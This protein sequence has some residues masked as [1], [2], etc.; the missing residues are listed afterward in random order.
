[1]F[2]PNLDVRRLPSVDVVADLSEPWPVPDG[3]YEGVYSAYILEHI[4]WRKAPAFVKELFR[5]LKPG[6][7]AFIVTSNTEAQM[8]W[9]L[10][11]EIF[12]E[13]IAQCLFG[14]NDYAENTHRAAFNPSYAVRLFRDAGFADVAVLPHGA[15]GTDMI[16]EAKKPMPDPIDLATVKHDAEMRRRAEPKPPGCQESGAAL[17]TPEQRKEA[18][19]RFYFDGGR[20]GV[21][22][23]ARE[24]YRDFPVHW[25]TFRKIMELNPGSVLELGCARGFVL[26][27]LEDAG[28]SVAG[29]DVSRHCYLTRACD[30]VIE[31]DLTKTPWPF[32]DKEFD[33]CISVA[34]LEHVPESAIGK[35]AAEIRRVS[36]RGLHGVDFGDHDDGFD[37]TH[38]LFRDEK[39]WFD[40]LNDFHQATSSMQQ[41]VVEKD[42]LEK[43]SI[44]LPPA[45]GKTKL[46]LGSSTIMYH[47]GWVNV[48][49]MDLGAWAAKEGYVFRRA[50]L[51]DAAQ[52]ESLA[53][54]GTVDLIH[55]SH[56]LEHF[57]RESGVALLGRLRKLLR[58]KGL[59]RIAVP[60]AAR[61]VK[62]YLEGMLDDLDDLND[63]CAST[64]DQSGKLWELLFSGH[65]AAYDRA[66]LKRALADAGFLQVSTYPFRRSRSPEMIRE[67]LDQYPDLSL[68]MEASPELPI[69]S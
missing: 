63:G 53:A 41:N 51:S 20:G 62:S 12:D 58:P 47:H 8:R 50:D 68:Y 46:N 28:V 30:R 15:L 11:Q 18:Y 66:S 7:T 60:D 34:V 29:M 25:T 26:R 43:G 69:E 4:S 48:D 24:G 19:N 56:V 9:A 16:V 44:T 6:G 67:T 49:S 32:K 5:V 65:R 22:G 42:D 2:R 14:D 10:A 38:V 27:R 52:V 40:K 13:K 39:W 23:Y 55:L 35:I 36:N 37:K 45:D 3:S 33:L 57:D 64:P 61:L 17:W 21:G 59:I 31:W 1:M 54:P